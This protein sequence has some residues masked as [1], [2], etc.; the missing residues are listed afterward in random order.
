M[1]LSD[2][3]T[4]PWPSWGSVTLMPIFPLA[5]ILCLWLL[6]WFLYIGWDM[7]SSYYKPGDFNQQNVFL[8][9][10]W[11]NVSETSLR[12]LFLLE[13]FGN[14]IVSVFSSSWGLLTLLF[15]GLHQ[16]NLYLSGLVPLPF[17]LCPVCPLTPK[18]CFRTKTKAPYSV[19]TQLFIST[20]SFWMCCK[21][22][23]WRKPT[24][25][26]RP[27]YL[28]VW[29]SC[30]GNMLEEK[31]IFIPFEL[32]HTIVKNQLAINMEVHLSSLGF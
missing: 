24:T 20:K 17:W 26:E 10:S 12:G 7:Y 27:H 16:C 9:S 6:N 32:S 3:S 28:Y 21:I 4:Q 22:F 1:T 31:S 13:V 30:L 19:S 15:L 23:K 11:G 14:N 2:V 18:V 25:E 29:I 8:H 5:L